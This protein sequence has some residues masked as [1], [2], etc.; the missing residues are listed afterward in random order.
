MAEGISREEHEEFRRRMEAAIN[1]L[2][3]RADKLEEVTDSI[4]SLATNTARLADKMDAMSTELN[5]QGKRL[6][7]LEGK[8]GKKWDRAVEIIAAALVGAV[9][10][11]IV[12]LF[13][14]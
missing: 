14:K 8:S 4:H 2:N 13:L 11:L 9:I 5:E 7:Q 3:D 6:V 10:P 1:G 12:Q